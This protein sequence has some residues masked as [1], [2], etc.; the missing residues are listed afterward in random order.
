MIH[1]IAWREFRSLFISPLAWVILAV[2]Q[3]I[4]GYLFLT[5]VDQYLLWQSRLLGMADAPGSTE[6]IVAPLFGN[7]AVILLL[8]VPLITMRVVSEERRNKTLGLLFSAPVTMTEIVLGKYLGIVF[9]LML[10][11]FMITLMPLSLLA[12]GGLDFG[13]LASG[14]LGLGLMLAAFAAVG[15]FMSTLT[16]TPTVAAISSFGVALLFWILDASGSGEESLLAYMSLLNHYEPF[17]R[18]IFN[19]T[20]AIYLLLFIATFLVMSVRRLDADRLGA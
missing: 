7:A 6:I 11:L 20:D 1:T 10:V 5:H 4:L 18:G 17:L 13:L 19:S 14:V 16:Q 12:G 2:V 15:L 9:F 3:L 8:V